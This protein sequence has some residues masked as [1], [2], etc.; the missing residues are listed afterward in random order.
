LLEEA[1]RT[2]RQQFGNTTLLQE[3]RREL[4]ALTSVESL[5]LD[6]RYALRTLWKN[7]AFAAVSVATLGL[8]IGAATAIFSVID[9]VLLAPFPYRG[10][11][12]IVFPRIHGEQQ[13]EDEGRQGYT[14]NEVLE[15]GESN[16]VFDESTATSGDLVLYKRGGGTEQLYA[17]NV[18]PGAFEFF[19]MAA[20]H[21]RVL[22][23]SDYEP[24][25][26]P[27]FVMGY[28][29]WK[30]QFGGD[31]SILNKTLA[32][33]GTERTLV[34]IMPPR[35]GWYGA[36]VYIPHKLTRGAASAG[37]PNWF[38]VG[39]LKPGVSIEQAQADLTVI[40]KRL[41]KTSPQDYPSQF[42]VVVKHMGDTVIGRFRETL[43]TVLAA[44]CLLLL[45]AC[46]NVANLMLARA[47]TREKEFALR[48]ALGARRARTI[49]LLMVES[50][51]LAIAGAALGKSCRLGRAEGAGGGD[52]ARLHS[53]RDRH[54]TECAGSGIHPWCC[55]ADRADFRLGAGPAIFET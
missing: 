6:L 31:L 19:G 54:S 38:L 17:T 52:A 35:F 7:R 20:L 4:Q 12:R 51:V 34:G 26:P 53:C 11:S 39:R 46:S 5:W 30:E 9:N 16:R 24:G 21:G 43:Y 47:T 33:N 2:A 45:I 29:I 25:A 42:K 32:L 41:A 49:R 44:V 55:R 37:P 10:A 18:T 27:V 14:A 28:K 50:L 13:S 3:D 15:I 36:D 8:G 48:A 1:A 23:P 40:A 22:Q